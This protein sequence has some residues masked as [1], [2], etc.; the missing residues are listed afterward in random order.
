MQG[1]R[2]DKSARWRRMKTTANNH[3]MIRPKPPLA[4]MTFWRSWLFLMEFLFLGS[5]D[6]LTSTAASAAFCYPSISGSSSHIIAPFDESVG[7]RYYP[8]CLDVHG[9]WD[10][11]IHIFYAERL[12]TWSGTACRNLVDSILYL[13]TLCDS[14]YPTILHI[15]LFRAKRVTLTFSVAKLVQAAFCKYQVPYSLNFFKNFLPSAGHPI[16]TFPGP[17]VK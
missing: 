14:S 17:G 16:K 13:W 9:W 7:L 6:L 3:R 10:A 5:L 1:K 2:L 12:T 15:C 8:C 4:V 11:L